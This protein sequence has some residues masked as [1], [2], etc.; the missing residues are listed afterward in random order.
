MIS[1][2]NESAN[3]PESL[4]SD[5]VFNWLDSVIVN[6]GLQLGEISIILCSED[7]ILAVNQTYL[8]HDYFTDIITFDY[9]ESNTVNGDLFVSVDTV[10]SNSI[11]FSVDFE[12][13]FLRVLVHGVLHLLGYKDKEASDIEL[14][15]QK[16]EYYLKK[17][18]SRET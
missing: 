7:Q 14:M 16:E 8:N 3:W 15:R 10:L 9:C 13:E 1:Y 18:V 6:E 4:G 12:S 2:F 17:Y 11:S 5:D